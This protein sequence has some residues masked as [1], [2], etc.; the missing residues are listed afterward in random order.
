MGVF[1]SRQVSLRDTPAQNEG[2]PSFASVSGQHGFR[3]LVWPPLCVA[4]A[5]ALIRDTLR[6]PQSRPYTGDFM[7]DFILPLV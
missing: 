1:V 3:M 2:L 7:C 6:G 5:F 4:G